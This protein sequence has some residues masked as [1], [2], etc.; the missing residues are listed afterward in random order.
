MKI[1]GILASHQRN[2]INAQLLAEVMKN[3]NESCEQETIFLEDYKIT[4]RKRGEKNLVLEELSE[5]LMQADV[6]VFAAPTYWR[7]LSGVLKN[8]FDCMRPKFVYFKQNG[9]T[10]P[11]PFKNKHYLSLTSC[12][13]SKTENFIT[14]VTDESFK[15]IDRVMST[16]GV[17]KV[18]EIVLPGTFGMKELPENK[19]KICKKYGEKISNKI[20][21]DDSTLKRYI[22]LFFMIAIMA[23]L[24]MGIQ[25]GL[26]SVV[27][28]NNFWINYV[29]FTII[30]FILL[31]IIL[32]F[33]TFMKHRRR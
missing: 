28:M 30:F 10:I 22:Q 17:I 18:G 19:K 3:V 12:Y 2:G 21:K 32:H 1:L 11:G 23:L 33:V 29:S 26:G 16:A 31:A 27:S 4:P 9:D 20:R 7:E 25:A 15:T 24:T 6:W 14:G 13:A 5:K 8:F